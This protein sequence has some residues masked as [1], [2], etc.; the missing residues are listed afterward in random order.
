MPAFIYKSVAY[1]GPFQGG[2]CVNCNVYTTCTSDKGAFKCSSCQYKNR[3]VKIQ[4]EK[5][6][7]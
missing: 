3:K 1:R 5:H 4:S 2:N 6:A 7:G